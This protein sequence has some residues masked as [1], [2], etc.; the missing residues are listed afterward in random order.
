MI[1]GNLYR[2]LF[3]SIAAMCI[4]SL[5]F[6]IFS[7][8]R[9]KYKLKKRKNIV[10]IG[11]EGN[12]RTSSLILPHWMNQDFFEYVENTIPHIQKC[13]KENMHPKTETETTAF[14]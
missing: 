7:L 8:K 2:V 12:G 10:V 3:L 13:M 9:N 11:G 4:A 14:Y 5:F 6:N 1:S